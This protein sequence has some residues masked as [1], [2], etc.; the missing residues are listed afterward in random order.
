M[1]SR[2]STVQSYKYYTVQFR[3]KYGH[4]ENI[5]VSRNYH[6]QRLA[7]KLPVFDRKSYMVFFKSVGLGGYSTREDYALT[8]E[9]WNGRMAITKGLVINYGEG[10]GYK[11]GKL[12]VRNFLRPPPQDR[13]KLFAPPL[14]KIGNFSRPPTIWLKL[15]A[16]T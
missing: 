1:R 3:E 14:L 2:K 7:S 13:V 15:Q 6:G 4:S 11:M 9:D 5:T 10:G 8:R 12:R 16:T